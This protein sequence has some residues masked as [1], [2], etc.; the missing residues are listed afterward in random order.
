MAVLW[1]ASVSLLVCPSLSCYNCFIKPQVSGRLCTG[2]VVEETGVHSVDECFRMLERIFTMNEKVTEAGRAAGGLEGKLKEILEAEITPIVTEFRGKLIMD[3]VYKSRLQK[4]AD[5]FIAAA[6]KL[7]RDDKCIPPCGF[8][9]I[10]AAY[11]CETC[12]YDSCLF[13]LDCPVEEIEVMENRGIEMQ[14]NVP[15]DLPSDIEVAWRFAEEFKTQDLEQFQEV[16]AGP[17]RLY[18]ISSTS[19]LNKGTYQCEIFSGTRS[20]VRLYFYVAV[21]PQPVAGHTALQGIF[22]LS[23]LPRGQ[24][25]TAPGAPPH[26]F[27]HLLLLLLTT[28]LAT[29]LLLLFISLG[30]LYWLSV[31]EVDHPV[32][33]SDEEDYFGVSLLAI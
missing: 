20:I 2:F 32:A 28:C 33:D 27:L 23:L 9:N 17:D 10:D 8:Q 4:A 6:S 21:T 3:T 19:S 7:P 30:F 14:C 26:F 11:N 1:L 31:S 5:N 12:R 22:D 24:L 16:T 13:P 15:F 25:P 29:S 18:S